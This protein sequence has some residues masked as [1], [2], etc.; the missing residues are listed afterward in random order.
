MASIP[1]SAQRTELRDPSGNLRGYVEQQG[2]RS[3]LRDK[4]GNPHGYW[5]Q[6]GGWRVH[7]D[8]AGNMLGREQINHASERTP[9]KSS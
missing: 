6:E 3:V 1:A 9:A 8:N 4:A 7:R 5:Q 2:S